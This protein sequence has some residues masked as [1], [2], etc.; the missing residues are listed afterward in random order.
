MTTLGTKSAVATRAPLGFHDWRHT[1]LN[2][3][4]RFSN[5]RCVQLNLR[6]MDPVHRYEYFCSQIW[7][8]EQRECLSGICGRETAMTEPTHT[9]LTAIDREPHADYLPTLTKPLPRE[10]EGLIASLVAFEFPNLI[11]DIVAARDGAPRRNPI[12]NITG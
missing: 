5:K 6:S 11:A 3:G 7:I 12:D 4:I 9:F 10:L 1:T 2:L 8:A